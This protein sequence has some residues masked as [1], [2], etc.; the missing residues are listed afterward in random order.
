MF[1]GTS[2]VLAGRMSATFDE[3]A[4]IG[5]GIRYLEGDF[6]LNHEHPPLAK[7]LGAIALPERDPPLALSQGELSDE[8]QWLFGSAWLHR[9]KQAPLDLLWRARMPLVLLNVWLIPCLALVTLK[10]LDSRAAMVSVLLAALCP[11]WLAHAMLVTTDAAA[12]LFIFAAVGCVLALTRAQS[13]RQRLPAAG[14]L[15]MC[16]SLALATK[17]S[18]LVLPGLVGCGALFDAVRFRSRGLLVWTAAALALGTALGVACAWGLPP[19][20]ALYLEG[21]AR[22]GANHRPNHELYAFGEFFRGQDPLYFARALAV[23][24]ALPVWLLAS[25]GLIAAARSQLR[26]GMNVARDQARALPAAV[27]VVPVGYFLILS[28]NAPALGVRYV[29]PVLPF[30]FL[31]AAYGAVQLASVRR[32]VALVT[33]CLLLQLGSY[34]VAIRNT[35][36]SFFN[37]LFCFS[38]DLEPCLDDSNLDWGQALPDLARYRER[39]YPAVPMR[40][41]Y[42]G[43]S[44]I[45]AYV[46]DAI[47][48]SSEEL[49]SPLPALYAIS[50][51]S[52]LRAP[53]Q[54]WARRAAPSAIV[55]GVYAI[56]DLRAVPALIAR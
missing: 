33:M 10:L 16:V 7:V 11:L 15:A 46:P 40:V 30:M 43:S 18:T 1:L 5:A 23:K 19:K 27:L 50:L 8:A 26:A 28:L 32:G 22:V 6:R 13:A 9:A 14:G 12:S 41:I 31:L 54:S 3:V 29:L 25:Y 48:V 42:F 20:P 4:H 36:L 52:R 56:Y 38:G 35:P 44:P 37:G 2:G 47:A 49:M 53:P 24:V 55:S 45:N 34:V 51:H 21:V 39:H 17:Y